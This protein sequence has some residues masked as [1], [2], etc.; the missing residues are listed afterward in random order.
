[1]KNKVLHTVFKRMWKKMR[2]YRKA[3][4]TDFLKFHYSQFGEDIVL[5]ELLKSEISDG[6]FVDVG[7]YHPKKYSNTYRLYRR[8][9]SGINID[10]E[11]DKIS[12]FNMVRSR[13]YNIL[14][15]ISDNREQVTL[16]RD[17]KYGLGS[18]IN[19]EYATKTSNDFFDNRVVETKTLNE[20]INES[21][22]NKKQIDVLS[23]DVEGM[24]F[25]VL[26]SLDLKTY[27]P[28]VIIIE[29]SHRS[30]EDILKSDIYIL[31][32][33]HSYVLR[34]WTFF[35]LIFVLPGADILKDRENE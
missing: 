17:G 13:D 26:N 3:F 10:M 5:K 20:I 21:P 12:L 35:S 16:F 2:L 30:I 1:M 19:K 18:T 32:K 31:L 27:R 34:S 33:K 23:I 24:D 22:Y 6:F 15:P 14:C 4:L 9:W 11:E 7:C 25:R 29:D 8:G 28:K